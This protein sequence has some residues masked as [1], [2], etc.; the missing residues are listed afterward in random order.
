MSKPKLTSLLFLGFIGRIAETLTTT[1]INPAGKA[2]YNP[3][4]RGNNSA[5]RKEH[6]DLETIIEEILPEDK[7]FD[8]TL[9]QLMKFRDSIS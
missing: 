6:F 2:E 7:D 8:P 3:K 4:E 5:K 9:T 1:G